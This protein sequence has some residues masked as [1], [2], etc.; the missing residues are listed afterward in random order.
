MILQ[1]INQTSST[2]RTGSSTHSLRWMIE[3]LDSCP[4]SIMCM[5]CEANMPCRYTSPSDN[6]S[7]HRSPCPPVTIFFTSRICSRGWML[8]L[9]P[10]I[11]WMAPRVNIV[12]EAV[13]HVH[14]PLGHA[15]LRVDLLQ[16]LED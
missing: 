5:H 10:I 14:G 6:T 15:Q 8:V 2:S 13:H 7:R 12:D 16:H 11:C 1:P 3:N 4:L 9:P